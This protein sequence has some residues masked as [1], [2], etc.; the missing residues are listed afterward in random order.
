MIDH[1]IG[2]CGHGKDVVDAL[3]MTTKKYIKQKM[4]IVSNPGNDE[5]ERKLKAYSLSERDSK[6][7]SFA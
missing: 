1:M 4:C 6:T 7:T 5:S 3:N 2:A